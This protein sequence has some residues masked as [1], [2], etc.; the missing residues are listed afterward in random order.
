MQNGRHERKQEQN[1]FFFIENNELARVFSFVFRLFDVVVLLPFSLL[2]LLLLW[3]IRNGVGIHEPKNKNTQQREKKTHSK[4]AASDW[5]RRRKKEKQNKNRRNSCL[6][7]YVPA[8]NSA[9]ATTATTA[10]KSTQIMHVFS[11]PRC[12]RHGLQ[13]QFTS[14][15]C[16][17]LH[18]FSSILSFVSVFKFKFE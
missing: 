3:E 9:T 11:P 5:T 2:L 4:S 14:S 18:I 15:T 12:V 1:N 7:S 8:A 13:F 17:F 10:T 16:F 6:S